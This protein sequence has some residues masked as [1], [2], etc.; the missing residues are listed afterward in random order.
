MMHPVDRSHVILVEV[1]V[2]LRRPDGC[3]AEHL[4]DRAKIRAAGEH[5]RC[6]GVTQIVR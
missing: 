6:E 1:G 5:V 3:V 4:L 2:D